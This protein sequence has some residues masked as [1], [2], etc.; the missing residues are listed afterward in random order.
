MPFNVLALN[1]SRAIEVYWQ[2]LFGDLQSLSKRETD[3]ACGFLASRLQNRGE[4][5]ST[6]S[7]GACSFRIPRSAPAAIVQSRNPSIFLRRIVVKKKSP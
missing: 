5:Y 4:T 6:P 2:E 1:V 7:P 3:C